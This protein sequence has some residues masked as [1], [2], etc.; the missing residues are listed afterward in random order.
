MRITPESL[1]KIAKTHSDSCVRRDVH[2]T[3]VYLTGSLVLDEPLLG[4]STDVDLIFV[5]D[6]AP[7]NSRELVRVS[8]DVHLDIAHYGQA[9]FQNTRSLRLDPW[10][11]SFLCEATR[12]LHD[13]VHWFDFTQAGVCSH[14]YH[15][16]NVLGRAR[17]LAESARQRWMQLTG[18]QHPNP[19]GLLVYLKTLEEAGNAIA[20]LTGPPLT[21]RRFMLQFPANC[22]T[23]GLPDLAAGMISLFTHE[24]VSEDNWQDWQTPWRAA[25]QAAAAQ[26]NCPP[27]LHACRHN[28]YTQAAAALWEG[29]PAAALWIFVRTWALAVTVL[30]ADSEHINAWQEPANRLALGI[31]HMTERLNALDMF[32]DQV[33][34]AVDEWAKKNGILE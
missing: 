4:G 2:I 10:L 20:C 33:E 11:G 34:G 18:G 19:H 21:E 29:A 27:R 12:V 9:A 25:L 26:S 17:S 31:E 8:D 7:K 16:E 5:H 23:V 32:L 30:P 1:L 3:C 13:R 15:P 24:D 14:F 22:Q 28:Y 6:V